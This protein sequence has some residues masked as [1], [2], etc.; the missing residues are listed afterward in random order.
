MPPYKHHLL[1]S[2]VDII[3]KSGQYKYQWFAQFKINWIRRHHNS[4][5]S[6]N[7]N[8]ST[9]KLLVLLVLCGS[10]LAVPGLQF[11]FRER[12]YITSSRNA[13]FLP[14]T[15]PFPVLHMTN[16]KIDTPYVPT[17]LSDDV[18][19]GRPFLNNNI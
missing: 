11:C 9:M 13:F 17:H 2:V 19:H 4:H 18:I 14:P 8:V 7:F 5:S 16:P 12:S 3:D 10:A 1:I 15:H 6:I